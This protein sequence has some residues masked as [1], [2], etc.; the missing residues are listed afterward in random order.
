VKKAAATLALLALSLLGCDDKPRGGDTAVV[1]ASA[2]A[3]ATAT[4]S[5]DLSPTGV[6]ACDDYIAKAAAC[7]KKVGASERERLRV[8]IEQ[9]RNQ[10]AQAKSDDAKEMVG[11]GCEAELDALDEDA[12]CK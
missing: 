8:S 11:V 1:A 4:P 7:M 12:T 5:T 6:K 9:Q 10:I 2:T 3:T